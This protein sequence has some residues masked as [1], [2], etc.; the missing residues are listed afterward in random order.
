MSNPKPLTGLFLGAGASAELGLPLV[1]ELT[2][3]VKQWLT[4]AKLRALNQGWRQQRTG[5]SDAVIDDLASVLERPEMH[6]ESILGHLETQYR[7][8][9]EFQKDY[10][11]LYSWLVEMVYHILRLRH[12]EIAKFIQGNVK[13][14]EGIARL[15]ASN[16][17][18]WAFSLNHDVILECV[19]AHFQI[20]IHSGF[21]DGL[22]SFPRRNKRGA[23]I[24]ELKAE[25]L[26]AEHLEA[27]ILFPQPGSDGI[28]LVKIHGALDVFTFREG[29]DL[30]RLLPQE[31]S[32]AGLTEMLRS[33]NEEL[34]YVVPGCPQPAKATN[35]VAYADEAGQMQ[36]LRRSLLAGA[37][38]FNDHRSQVLPAHVLKQFE[39]NIHHVSSL[40]CIGYSFGDLHIN[41]IFRTWLEAEPERLLEIVSPQATSVPSFLLHLSPQV[42]LV[43]DR[44]T[45]YL[46]R[47]TGIVR[48]RRDTLDKQFARW[49]LKNRKN[50]QA[51]QAHDVFLRDLED[52]WIKR[53][54]E[55]L[56]SLPI[57]DGDLDCEALGRT[58]QE[59]GRDFAEEKLAIIESA[60]AAFLEDHREEIPD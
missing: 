52:R 29:K 9:P 21:N 49:F 5:F 38:K 41:Q 51:A 36:F 54:Q 28:N 7:R 10:H 35:E 57:R 31:A 22:V 14:F 47:V 3:E 26:T 56:E 34:I 48:S 32:V 30:A 18:L 45:D 11:G 33:A 39:S 24:G 17:P 25:T 53:F 55:K 15:A 23:V 46:D 16:K 2:N 44:A 19:A 13:A 8:A 1:W 6:Y 50:I 20:P 40:V 4:P 42:T 58:P 12:A 27:G 60:L 43:P 59:L 37:Y